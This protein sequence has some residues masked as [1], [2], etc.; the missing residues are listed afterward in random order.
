MYPRPPISSSWCI[1]S[2]LYSCGLPANPHEGP[3]A[4]LLC[5]SLQL[6]PNSPS[7]LKHSQPTRGMAFRADTRVLLNH[8]R[9]TAP[10]PYSTTPVL[11]STL[12]HCSKHTTPAM[13]LRHAHRARAAYLAHH[14]PCPAGP[15]PACQHQERFRCPGPAEHALQQ[16]IAFPAGPEQRVRL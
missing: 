4:A 7:P 13:T 12:S 3:D 1:S 8:S 16:L 5:G 2:L 10:A 14:A 15:S 9:T 11:F 6:H